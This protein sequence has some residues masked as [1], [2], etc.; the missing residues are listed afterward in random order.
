MQ[1]IPLLRFRALC[2]VCSR[3][4]YAFFAR[5]VICNF[6]VYINDSRLTRAS[7]TF[8]QLKE[9]LE[10]FRETLREFASKNKKQIKMNPD[11]RRQFSYLC[12]LVGIDPLFC[13]LYWC[14]V[15]CGILHSIACVSRRKS[16]WFDRKRNRI[17]YKYVN[18]IES[19]FQ[20]LPPH[21][22]VILFF[23]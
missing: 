21:R 17:Y 23:I 20:L 7:D 16:R 2:I 8:F 18:S 15:V 6:F 1:P 5:R 12:S 3:T 4:S 22:Y 19:C 13:K 14:N 9:Q 11:F 10:T